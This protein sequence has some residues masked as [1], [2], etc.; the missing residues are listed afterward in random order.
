MM[1][2]G[3]HIC[4]PMGGVADFHYAHLF[5]AAHVTTHMRVLSTLCP[6]VYLRQRETSQSQW[7][8]RHLQEAV[9][10]ESHPSSI[11]SGSRWSQH[12]GVKYTTRFHRAVRFEKYWLREKYQCPSLPSLEL[13]FSSC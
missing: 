2:Q 6:S 10:A 4:V 3:E 5:T 8:L 11:K 9:G 7:C 1:A 12:L 13:R